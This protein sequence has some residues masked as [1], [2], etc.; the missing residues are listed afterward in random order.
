MR[1]VIIGA[2]MTVVVAGTAIA[3]ATASG[4][5]FDGKRPL[6]CTAF[7]FFECDLADGCTPVTAEEIGAAGSWTMDF[8]KKEVT[9]TTEGSQPNAIAHV[10]LLDGKLFLTGV[11]DGLPGERDGVAWS[12]SINNP[13]GVMTIMVA[14][15]G[16]GIVGLGS[17]VPK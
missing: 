17:C 9:G 5:Q 3:P 14:G 12:V 7:R 8:K 16:V 2:V 4:E 6:L 15:E 1:T 13:N 11:Q 10:E